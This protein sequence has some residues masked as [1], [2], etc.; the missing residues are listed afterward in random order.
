MRLQGLTK[1]RSGSF[2]MVQFIV[3]DMIEVWDQS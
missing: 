2:K 1:T 3:M